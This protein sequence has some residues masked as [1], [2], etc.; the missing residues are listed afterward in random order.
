MS[1]NSNFKKDKCWSCEYYCGKRD[2]KRGVILGDSVSTDGRGTC[3][4]KRSNNYNKSVNDDGWC[5]RYQKWGVLLSALALEA[6]KRE[7][8]RIQAEQRREMQRIEAENERQRREMERERERME[9][10][11]RKLERE[12]LLAS[13]TPEERERFLQK[14]RDDKEREIAV[15]KQLQLERAEKDRLRKIQT[16]KDAIKSYKRRP[17][18]L[19]PIFGG[20]S[21]LI[22]LLVL[23]KS[24]AGA[25]ITLGIL[26]VI[27]LIV[28]LVTKAVSN[29][30]ITALNSENKKLESN[31]IDTSLKITTET[32]K[33]DENTTEYVHKANGIRIATTTATIMPSPTAEEL[34]MEEYNEE[35]AYLTFL[36]KYESIKASKNS[37]EGD[38][39]HWMFMSCGVKEVKKL[40]NELEDQGFYTKAD[41]L[42]FVSIYKVGELKDIAAKIGIDVHG[43]KE[44][45]QRQI[46]EST[47]I[48]KLEE[49]TG[50]TVDMISEKGKS[51][52]KDNEL[53][54][55]YYNSVDTSTISFD[56][57]MK[58]R[59]TNAVEDIDLKAINKD[60]KNDKDNF[61]RNGYYRRYGFYIDHN[62]IDLAFIDLLTVLRIDLS[63]VCAY[64][65]IKEYPD[66]TDFR[67]KEFSQIYFAPGII[68]EIKSLKD[69]FNFG[70]LD[71]V[72][73]LELP[74][75]ATDKMLMGEILNKI[76]SGELNN[77]LQNAYRDKLNNRF[78]EKAKEI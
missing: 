21:L 50:V 26:L 65:A 37:N 42:H 41:A 77:E 47:S 67:T 45:I 17:I 20:I 11:R 36:H 19:I 27:S 13:M 33:V 73:Q 10:E 40:H 34:F 5:S 51:Y 18:I 16:N 44:D 59:E 32:R 8:E 75:D 38:Y 70:M 58:T 66:E 25:F 43:K 23:I 76:F 71:K 22:F 53:K 69:K 30:K 3:S 60:I 1:I 12:R 62:E 48:E 24:V 55:E 63:G 14:E 78:E 74:L 28:I 54:W 6:E 72:Y 39:P 15:A 9:I 4:N 49:I 35:K 56:E 2:Y 52:L 46:A 7:S 57:F 61:G 64:K 29:N 68:N 31:P